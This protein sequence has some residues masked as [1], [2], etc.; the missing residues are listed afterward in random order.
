MGAWVYVHQAGILSTLRPTHFRLASE[1]L[2]HCAYLPKVRP[3]LAASGAAPTVTIHKSTWN[4]GVYGVRK[5]QLPISKLPS[6]ECHRKRMVGWHRNLTMIN[7]FPLGRR[8]RERSTRYYIWVSAPEVEGNEW[9]IRHAR[10]T[11][12][13]RMTRRTERK[14]DTNELHISNDGISLSACLLG[15]VRG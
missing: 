7:Y 1:K 10:D 14:K 8:W 9:T 15:V 12:E 4:K 2:D 11:K 13:D 6:I 5:K 3:I